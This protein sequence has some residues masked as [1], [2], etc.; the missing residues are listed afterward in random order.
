MTNHPNRSKAALTSYTFKIQTGETI[1]GPIW[2]AWVKKFGHDDQAE[3]FAKELSES[4]ERDE[5]GNRVAVWISRGD[6]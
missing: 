6:A 5:N 2:E 1:D 3:R 4:W